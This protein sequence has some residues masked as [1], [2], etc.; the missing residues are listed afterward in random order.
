MLDSRHR[1]HLSSL[2]G[3]VLELPRTQ[4]CTSCR[5]DCIVEVPNISDLVLHFFSSISLFLFLH[6]NKAELKTSQKKCPVDFSPTLYHV[7]HLT[8]QFSLLTQSSQWPHTSFME[9]SSCGVVY[10]ARKVC[11]WMGRKQR[12]E[13]CVSLNL[14]VFKLSDG[15]LAKLLQH[16]ERG[17]SKTMDIFFQS[18]NVIIVL[19]LVLVEG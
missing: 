10:K 12:F 14:E 6:K 2:V 9:A 11:G 7:D 13:S 5:L 3:L 1:R 15:N 19:P 17:S 16:C 4:I 8:C 18:R